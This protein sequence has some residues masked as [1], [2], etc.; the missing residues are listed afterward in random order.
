LAPATVSI[1]IGHYIQLVCD[2]VN[3]AKLRHGVGPGM[4]D[5]VTTRRWNLTVPSDDRYRTW[6]A[7][8][9]IN[10]LNTDV[11]PDRHQNCSIRNRSDRSAQRTTFE[12]YL[13]S[14]DARHESSLLA[15]IFD[16]PTSLTS[17]FVSTGVWRSPPRRCPG[18]GTRPPRSTLRQPG[19]SAIGCAAHD[20]RAA[21]MMFGRGDRE[22][23]AMVDAVG[24]CVLKSADESPEVIE[25][26]WRVFRRANVGLTQ[27]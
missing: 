21:A 27:C 26:L 8:S 13:S 4:F 22:T 20:L 15:V 14:L 1:R 7:A 5:A 25:I 16:E 12:R 19:R 18:T 3:L 24:N 17:A 6:W 10:I 9:R 2:R 11:R 23:A